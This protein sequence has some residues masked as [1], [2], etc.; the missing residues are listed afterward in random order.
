MSGHRGSQNSHPL[1]TNGE[2]ILRLLKLYS[3]YLKGS[4]IV[5]DSTQ[6]GTKTK[7]QV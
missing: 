7:H 6:D 2:E 4:W 1:L 5:L 3:E